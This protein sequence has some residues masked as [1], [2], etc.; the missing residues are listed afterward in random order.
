MNEKRTEPYNFKPQN[1]QNR[2]NFA[3]RKV[4]DKANQNQNLDNQQNEQQGEQPH[5]NVQYNAF[6][7]GTRKP[8]Q[9]AKQQR[10]NR[11]KN[12]DIDEQ[13]KPI[14]DYRPKPPKPE[15]EPNPQPREFNPDYVPKLQPTEIIPKEKITHISI[16]PALIV[17]KKSE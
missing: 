10:P 12:S 15:S 14:N 5:S 7:F 2:Q 17:Q 11:H 8:N 1:L 4:E 6:N 9:K 13:F 3:P 16:N